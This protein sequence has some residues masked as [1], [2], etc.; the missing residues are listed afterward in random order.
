[1]R[2][3]RNKGEIVRELKRD[4]LHFVEDSVAWWLSVLEDDAACR[5]ERDIKKVD[6]FAG[7][8][9][10]GRNAEEQNAQTEVPGRCVKNRQD[11]S[12]RSD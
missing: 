9:N 4:Q 8:D 7:P 3:V 12:T 1:M 10:V 5:I 2:F 6:P 11:V